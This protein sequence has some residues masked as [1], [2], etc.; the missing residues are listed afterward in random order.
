MLLYTHADCLEHDTGPGHPES[1]GR[2]QTILGLLNRV[3][4]APLDRR[5]APLASDDLLRLAH[6][7]SYIDDL[8]AQT[9]AEGWRQVD[10]DTILSPGSVRAARR[11][12]GAAAAAVEAVLGGEARIAFCAIRPPGHHAERANAMGFCLFSNAAIAALHALNLG[13]ERVAVVDFDV[14]HGNGTQDVLKDEPRALFVSMHES[15]LYPHTGAAD[16]TGC[17]NVMNLPMHPEGTSAE[18][19]AAYL[20]R[21]A[22]ALERFA[23]QLIIISA[24]FDAHRRDPLAT[25]Q[26]E[27]E[28]YIWFTDQLAAAARRSAQG[29]IVSLLEGGYDLQALAEASGAHIQRLMEVEFWACE[30]PTP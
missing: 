26:L 24:G 3:A 1:R 4:F 7:Q 18:W 23:P 20:E 9:P 11:G 2:L 28:D 14:H 17:G 29:R 8:V 5:E 25:T 12:A 6:P 10:S 30:T 27:T 22:P 15:P 13:L 21:V 19:R 16:E